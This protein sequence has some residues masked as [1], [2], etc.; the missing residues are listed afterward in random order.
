MDANWKQRYNQ[1]EDTRVGRDMD[2]LVELG[3]R[4]ACLALHNEYGFGTQ[5]IEHI[6]DTIEKYITVYIKS[7]AKP[8]TDAYRH[9]V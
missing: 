9:T 6:R 5:R 8:H 3:I 2:K 4:F 1:S 7:G